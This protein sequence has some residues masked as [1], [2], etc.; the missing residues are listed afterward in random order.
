MRI[1]KVTKVAVQRITGIL[2]VTIRACSAMFGMVLVCL[3]VATVDVIASGAPGGVPIFLQELPSDPETWWCRWFRGVGRWR[4]WWLVFTSLVVK[5]GALVMVK[6]NVGV[7][8]GF[9][10]GIISEGA[11]QD[12]G[13]GNLLNKVTAPSLIRSDPGYGPCSW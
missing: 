9:K 1:R 11:R 7:C 10:D 6:S 13:P 12:R 2:H 4:Q 3:V 8:I 5:E